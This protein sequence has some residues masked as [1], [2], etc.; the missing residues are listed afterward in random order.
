MTPTAKA[1]IHALKSGEHIP[2]Y[3]EAAGRIGVLSES[4]SS[5]TIAALI[6][7][8]TLVMDE[9]GVVTLPGHPGSITNGTKAAQAARRRAKGVNLEAPIEKHACLKCGRYFRVEYN[10]EIRT[11][12]GTLIRGRRLAYR[13]CYDCRTD[14][15]RTGERK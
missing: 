4:S 10:P 15:N 3:T 5:R 1:L 6:M 11:P 2:S 14:S 7:D 8:G 9:G 12:L 13:T